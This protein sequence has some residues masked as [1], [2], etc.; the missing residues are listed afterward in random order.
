MEETVLHSS[1]KKAQDCLMN[2]V[3]EKFA[4]STE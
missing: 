2:P 1:P 3:F 4:I